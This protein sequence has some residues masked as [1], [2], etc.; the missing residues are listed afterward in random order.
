[1]IICS[2]GG[3]YFILLLLLLCLVILLFVKSLAQQ[4]RHTLLGNRAVLNIVLR[5]NFL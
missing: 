5:G 3:A 1:M 4:I 2:N